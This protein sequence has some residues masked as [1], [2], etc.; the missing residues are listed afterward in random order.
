MSSLRAAGQWVLYLDTDQSAV[1]GVRGRIAVTGTINNTP[2]SGTLM[3][4]KNGRHYLPLNKQIRDKT[5][6]QLDEEV[7][8]KLRMQDKDAPPEVP[9]DMQQVLAQSKQAKEQFYKMPPS[10][11][12]EFIRWVCDAKRPETRALRIEKTLEMLLS[13]K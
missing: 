6:I 8:L 13:D 4:D 7:Q 5:G 9:E 2:I 1:F 3:P 10:H 12:K 11:Q